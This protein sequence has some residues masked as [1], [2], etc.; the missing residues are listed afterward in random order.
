MAAPTTSNPRWRPP[1]RKIQDG[2]PTKSDTR[3]RS[4]WRVRLH[5]WGWV[6][7][8]DHEKVA[9]RPRVRCRSSSLYTRGIYG[10]GASH[11]S[12][13]TDLEDFREGSVFFFTISERDPVFNGVACRST[14]FIPFS[15]WTLFSA[16]SFHVFWAGSA[17][18]SQKIPL[19]CHPIAFGTYRKGLGLAFPLF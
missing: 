4:M 19:F 3:W 10:W 9:S 12:N 8:L 7:A 5:L 11:L 1:Q 13:S 6:N 15:R 14:W 2:G 18:S 16:R 17:F